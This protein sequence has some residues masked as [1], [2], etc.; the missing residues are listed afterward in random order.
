M[1]GKSLFFNYF[2]TSL[3]DD[4]LHPTQV[5]A[6]SRWLRALLSES[7]YSTNSSP[8]S[9]EVVAMDL[10]ESDSFGAVLD[11]M[12]GKPLNLTVEVLPDMMH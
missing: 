2:N 1:R 11:Y 12:Y 8:T 3:S 9:D 7:C 4:L 6:W 5:S 10:F